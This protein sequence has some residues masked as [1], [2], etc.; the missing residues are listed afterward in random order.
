[1]P[2]KY[3]KVIDEMKEETLIITEYDLFVIGKDFM[4]SKFKT[5]DNLPYNKKIM[6][7]CVF[8]EKK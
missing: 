5:N 8:L 6:L 2:D 7:K 1:M 4:R 3:V